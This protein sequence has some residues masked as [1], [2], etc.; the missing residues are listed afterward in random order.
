MRTRPISTRTTLALAAIVLLTPL[1][2]ARVHAAPSRPYCAAMICADASHIAK[3]SLDRGPDFVVHH[4]DLKDGST[5]GVYVGGY[6]QR[7]AQGTPTTTETIDGL[8]CERYA[9]TTD[10]APSIAVYCPWANTFPTVIHAWAKGG[11]KPEASQAMALVK[12]LRR[13]DE[14]TECP[15]PPR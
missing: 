11:A 13:C 1:I 15:W 4:F 10:G 5:A 9:L 7:P 2:A 6:P 14:K 12:S 8:R 3:T